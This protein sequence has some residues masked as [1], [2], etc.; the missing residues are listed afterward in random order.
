MAGK[1]VSGLKSWEDADLKALRGVEV[2]KAQIFNAFFPKTAE[3][4]NEKIL[5]LIKVQNKRLYMNNWRILKRGTE[6]ANTAY[7]TLSID[8]QSAKKL[9]TSRFKVSK[10]GRSHHQTQRQQT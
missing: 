1:A 2:P 4:S 5:K 10:D 6:G 9:K 7:I 8:D 3:D